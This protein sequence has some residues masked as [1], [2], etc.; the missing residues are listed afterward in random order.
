M[1]QVPQDPR[2]QV[3]T[4]LLV[5]VMIEGQEM[6]LTCHSVENDPIIPGMVKFGLMQPLTIQGQLNAFQLTV[7]PDDIK[8]T[9]VVN[10]VQP[11]EQAGEQAT[12]PE[13]PDN[14]A[15]KPEAAPAKKN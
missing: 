7:H 6:A 3:P 14:G 2:Q 12:Q 10:P 5:K 4:F 15:G 1:S 9:A 11:P 8:Y 13:V